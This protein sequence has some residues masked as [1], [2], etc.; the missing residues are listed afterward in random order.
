MSLSSPAW[1]AVTFPIP[2]TQ[3]GNNC[4]GTA[5]AGG[6]FTG[7]HIDDTGSVTVIDAD[8]GFTILAVAIQDGSST[9]GLG[10]KDCVQFTGGGTQTFFAPT[11]IPCWTVVWSLNDTRVTITETN[12]Q[13]CG[14]I[15]H[16]QINQ[17]PIVNTNPS[18]NPSTNPNTNAVPE[19]D[20][21]VL[22]GVGALGLAGFALYKRRRGLPM[23]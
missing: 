13:G 8:T 12:H 7:P 17:T 20:S 5:D 11:G 22:F 18:T 4:I 21:F 10:P 16:I 6:E 3:Q 2:S 23:G 14:D 1:A 19:L 9:T 15:S